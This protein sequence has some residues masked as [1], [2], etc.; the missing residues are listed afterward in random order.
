MVNVGAESRHQPLQNHIGKDQLIPIQLEELHQMAAKRLSTT[1]SAY[2]VFFPSDANIT[3]EQLLTNLQRHLPT[4]EQR[5]VNG[6]RL[7][8]IIS[9]ASFKTHPN[10]SGIGAVFS[11]FEHG[12]T[13][14]TLK[15]ASSNLDLS[16]GE[17]QAE[18]GE[19]FLDS[20]VCIFVVENY[21]LACGLGNRAATLACAISDMA[22]K[23][24]SVSFQGD[25]QIA[26]IPNNL[27]LEDIK[28]H[29][30]KQIRFN[31]SNFLGSLPKNLQHN[32]V[33]Q[34]FG[35]TSSTA[36]I[37]RRRNTTATLEMRQ[38]QRRSGVEVGV[39]KTHVDD[40]LSDVAAEAVLSD[41]VPSYTLL[42]NNDVQYSSREM[43]LKKKI[44]VRK[45]GSSFHLDDAHFALVEYYRE[46][47][48]NKLIT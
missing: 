18:D 12:R 44:D 32:L 4:H 7:D 1:I 40:W 9:L 6:G 25:F 38:L 3:L 20:N 8:E 14:S 10:N 27:T 30:V 37:E 19:E 43:H 45:S 41:E 24:G 39:S 48:A 47:K 5:Q 31:I 17:Q 13:M 15:L 11:L 42:L 29:G 35:S 33:E 28:K 46:L 2:R 34:V 22:K 23:C 36:D 21:L 26:G 16:H